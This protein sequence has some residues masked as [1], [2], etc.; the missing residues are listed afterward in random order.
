MSEQVNETEIYYHTTA[1]LSE[2]RLIGI[3][4]IPDLWQPREKAAIKN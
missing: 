2:M 3:H 4:I 1:C